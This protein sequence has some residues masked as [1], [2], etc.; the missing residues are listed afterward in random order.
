[1][2]RA[3]VTDSLYYQAHGQCLTERWI[4]KIMPTAKDE[5]SGDEIAADV[6][7]RAGLTPRE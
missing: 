5:R 3:Y 6:I 2:Y 4:E 7:A 1:M